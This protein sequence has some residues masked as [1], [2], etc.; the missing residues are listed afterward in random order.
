MK[1]NKLFV[2]LA[3]ALALVVFAGGAWYL[4]RKE[5]AKNDGMGRVA[6]SE[7]IEDHNVVA[8]P[9]DAKVTIVEFF[10][11]ECEACREMYLIV[12][13]L[14]KEY[15]GKLRV[16][17]RYMPFHGNAMYAASVIEEARELGKYDEAMYALFENQPEWGSHHEPRPDLIPGYLEKIGI[18]PK[19]LQKDEVIKK[20]GWKVE[21]DFAAGKRLGVQKTP[22]YFVNGR[23]LNTIGYEVLKSAIEAELQR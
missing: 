11:P 17:H 16:V 8:G 13:H 21:K 10:D 12:K 19:R 6:A 20:H 2:V 18:D 1:G 23:M 7:L 3:A 9:A 4:S 22:T 15:E 14:L 5:Q